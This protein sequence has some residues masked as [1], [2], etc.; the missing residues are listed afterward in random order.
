MSHVCFTLH[1]GRPIVFL[2]LL[3]IKVCER[4]FARIAAMPKGI[5]HEQEDELFELYQ[6]QIEEG[7]PI[8][9]I[10]FTNSWIHNFRYVNTSYL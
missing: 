2:T 9:E 3:L 7:M 4:K 10:Y 1:W 6:I 8:N 5:F